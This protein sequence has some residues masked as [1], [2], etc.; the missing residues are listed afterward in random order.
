MRYSNHYIPGNRIVD[1]DS[2]GFTYRFLQMRRGVSKG[3]KGLV[4]C[5]VCYSPIH[6]DE[7]PFTLNP[8]KPLKKVGE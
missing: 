3:Q 7:I 4:I 6:P 8:K 1:C 5:P 2:C